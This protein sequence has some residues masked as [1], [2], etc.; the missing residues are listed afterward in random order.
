MSEEDVKW[1]PD[2]S[3][4]FTTRPWYSQAYLDQRCEHIL[5]EF[6][7]ELYG[8]ITLPLP[9]G[10]LI[11]L[12][13]RDAKELN[14]HAD[15]TQVEPRI[16]GVT[17]FEP[18]TKPKVSIAGKL[19][20][21]PH[22]AHLFRFTLAHEYIHVR[23]HGPLY[24]QAGSARRQ[25]NRCAVDETLGLRP[26]VDW[27]EWHSNYG[28]GAL[29]MPLSRLKLTAEVCL[30]RGGTA[31]LGV[32]S[33]KANDLIQRISEAFDVSPEAVRV[34]LIQLAYLTSESR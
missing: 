10:A 32:D 34:R 25:A 11:K 24:Q 2:D 30:G 27:M 9:T 33:P 20:R 7:N 3:G 14:L 1:I 12:I 31:P 21:D 28:A 6:L 15:L 16:L 13:E 19:Y 22:A 17:D 29:L 26:K 8:H 5:F 4:R 18:P 23:A